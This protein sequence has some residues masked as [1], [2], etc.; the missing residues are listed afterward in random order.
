MFVFLKLA[1]P[2]FLKTLMYILHKIMFVYRS[3]V[4]PNYEEPQKICVEI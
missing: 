2:D 4:S 3:H 1:T